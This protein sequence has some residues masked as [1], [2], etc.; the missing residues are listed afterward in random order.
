MIALFS[1]EKIMDVLTSVL[2]TD[3]NTREEKIKQELKTELTTREYS[4]RK[5]KEDK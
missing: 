5:R 4:L 1:G 3:D 2:I